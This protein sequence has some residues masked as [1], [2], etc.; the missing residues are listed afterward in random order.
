[1]IQLILILSSSSRNQNDINNNDNDNNIMAVY[2]KSADVD[3]ITERK[4][5]V[6]KS[7]KKQRATDYKYKEREIESIVV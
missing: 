3:V 6:K 4:P 1:M 2:A 5:S 7:S